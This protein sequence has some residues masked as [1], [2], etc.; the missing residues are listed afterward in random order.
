[1]Y[2]GLRDNSGLLWDLRDRNKIRSYILQ[3]TVMGK[4]CGGIC[5]LSLTP[6]GK[7]ALIGSGNGITR[8]WDFRDTNNMFWDCLQG[9]S[10]SSS[11]LT[12]DGKWAL[13]VSPSLDVNDD[14]DDDYCGGYE[15]RE[16]LDVNVQFWI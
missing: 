9:R 13:T 3:K 1:M 5:S 6:D 16:P 8:L 2:I 10:I 15:D 4:S 11:S 12:P 14:E 7:Y